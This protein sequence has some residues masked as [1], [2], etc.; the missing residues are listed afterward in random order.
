MRT[1]G[2]FL[3]GIGAYVPPSVPTRTAVEE[4]RYDRESWAADGWLGAAVAGDLAAPDL[5]VRAARQALEGADVRPEEFRL[6]LHAGTL[7]QGPDGWPA[8][9]YVQRHTVGGSAPAMEVRQA[10]N[11]MLAA[12]GLAAG[13]LAGSAG[14]A[15]LTGADNFGTPLVDRWRYSAGAGTN[16]GSV[17]GDAGTALVL[18]RRAG[19]AEVLAVGSVSMPAGEEL[20]RDEHPLFP[21]ACTVGRPMALGSRFARFAA[22]D[23]DAFTRIKRTLQE[24]RTAL[25]RRTLAEAGVLPEQITRAVHLFSGGEPYV[26]SVLEPI[27][28][29][30]DRG[31]LDY[32]RRVGHLGVND[33]V[34]A[35]AHLIETRALGP[36]D[37]VLLVNNGG[38]FSASCVVLRLRHLPA[39]PQG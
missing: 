35:L 32:G 14:A 20:Y 16:R 36:G 6:V 22:A 1:D 11:G 28:I 18:S 34:A 8:S 21:P 12:V 17:L 5:A 31:V 9:Q 26:R 27:G 38:A 19:F 24:E 29:D 23:R 39:R 4:G 15:L 7:H 10:C 30:A 37:H 25:A 3:A 2:L 33:H 13:Y